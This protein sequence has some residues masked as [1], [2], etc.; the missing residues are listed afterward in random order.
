[1]QSTNLFRG[2]PLCEICLAPVTVDDGIAVVRKKDADR[3]EEAALNL[4]ET[5]SGFESLETLNAAVPPKVHWYWG[6][7]ACVPTD[8]YYY[9]TANRLD[10]V[11]KIL[12]WTL[13]LLIDKGWVD[14]IGWRRLLLRLYDIP[15]A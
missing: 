1:M 3:Y 9:I 8:Y 2:W 13:H 4:S 5:R 15:S 7:I 11:V 10:D 12:E 14:P 6:H